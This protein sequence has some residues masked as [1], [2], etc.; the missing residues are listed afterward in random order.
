[1]LTPS[2]SG[3]D[4]R[5]SFLQHGFESRR[6]HQI[7]Y[8]RLSIIIPVYNEINTISVILKRIIK[9]TS[10]IKKDLGWKPKETFESG[11]RKT[12]EWYLLNKEWY[13]NILNKNNLPY[14]DHGR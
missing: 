10:K 14:F 5:F 3:Q 2:S 1:M 9:D 4:S 6:G 8:M 11:L 12:V 13:Q 7:Y